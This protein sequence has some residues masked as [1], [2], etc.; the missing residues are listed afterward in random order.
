M[1][2]CMLQD[3]YSIFVCRSLDEHLYAFLVRR[4]MSLLG[5]FSSSVQCLNRVGD[6]I[7]FYSAKAKLTVWLETR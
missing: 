7:T 3:G 5:S 1:N 4:A 6:W 2:N